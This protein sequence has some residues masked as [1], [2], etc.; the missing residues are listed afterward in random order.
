M[1]SNEY[2]HEWAR[3]IM[4]LSSVFS[5]YKTNCKIR[6]VHALKK[7]QYYIYIYIYIYIYETILDFKDRSHI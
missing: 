6:K 3:G 1:V 2:K 7:D 4:R 5:R